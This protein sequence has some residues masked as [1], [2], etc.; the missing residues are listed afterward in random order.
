MDFKAL[1][2]KSKVSTERCE[3]MVA[4]GKGAAKR[5]TPPLDHP[6]KRG[7]PES[8]KTRGSA[9]FRRPFRPET[10]LY[11]IQGLCFACPWLPYLRAFSALLWTFEAKRCDAR[12]SRLKPLIK[13]SLRQSTTSL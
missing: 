1:P 6:P 11:P 12:R 10:L 2:Q 7:S 9:R 13:V 3:E 8:A 5:S 4:R